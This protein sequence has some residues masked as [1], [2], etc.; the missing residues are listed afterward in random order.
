MT[1]PAH[2]PGSGAGGAALETPYRLALEPFTGAFSAQTMLGAAEAATGLGDW[3]G[4]RWDEERFRHDFT[5]LC[6]DLEE[7]A[8]LTPAGR[9][10]ARSRLHTI[11][12]SRLRYIAARQA[13]RGVDAER[14]VAPLIGMGMPRA[15]TTF[16][17]ALL[18]QDPANRA[19][20][21]FEA[22]IP[23]P[24]DGADGDIRC[25]LFQQILAFQGLLD[26]AVTS[27][28]PH[29]S[30]MP[31]ECIFLQEPDCNSLWGVYWNV[32][33][34]AQ[35]I[36]G[37][38]VSAFKWQLGVMQYL[39]ATGPEG[40]WTL[41]APGHIFAW[42]ELR[43]TFPD[44][45]IYVN[46]RDPARVIPSIASLLMV[47]RHTFSDAA[48]D[49]VALGRGQLAA[50]SAGMNRYTDWRGGEGRD[51]RVADIHFTDLI[52]RPVETVRQLYDRFGLRF[53]PQFRE[54]MLRHL[55]IDHHGKGAS[56]SYAL[57]D[58]GIDEA[59]IERAFGGYIDQFAIQREK[60]G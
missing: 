17:H 11:L 12:V 26:P 14:I 51:A 31:D 4:R 52:A 38:Q 49:P 47:L 15:G 1:G 58:Y 56:R 30:D 37:K 29:G 39:Q 50:W 5:I 33:G 7:T 8:H 19:P 60:R 10:R 54:R 59:M 16:L 34:F 41:K 45:L 46:H 48:I 13:A 21:S 22:A 28:H 35:A 27:I 43:M 18:A 9:S 36:A 25:Q 55:E 53:T 24:L 32:P 23:V 6:Q 44:A 40:R 42:D 57:G 20:R 2:S 3:G